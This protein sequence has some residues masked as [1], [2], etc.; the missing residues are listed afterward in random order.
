MVK[1]RT[2]AHRPESG[3]RSHVD[4]PGEHPWDRIASANVLRQETA[5]PDGLE[6]QQRS[7]ACWPTV[8]PALGRLKQEDC[9]AFGV[10][11]ARK[12]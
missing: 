11:T 9:L 3:W 5:R 4:N 1:V 6:K 8:V 10:R 12:G 2:N 7:W